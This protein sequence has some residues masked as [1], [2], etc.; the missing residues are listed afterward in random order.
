VNMPAQ[1]QAG[2]VTFQVTNNGDEV[3][4]FE[5]EGEG[6]E[7]SFPTDLQPGETRSMTVELQPGTYH[8]YCPVGDHEEQGM[9]LEL[10]V[11]GQ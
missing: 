4:N 9:E 5:I 10:E 1:V 3:H 7:E 8:V 6:V 11:T 2:T